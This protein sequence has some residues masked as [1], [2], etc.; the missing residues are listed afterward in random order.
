MRRSVVRPAVAIALA[1]FVVVA[2][3]PRVAFAACDPFN[4]YQQRGWAWMYGAFELNLPSSLQDRLSQ[5]GGR[6]FRGAFAMGMVGGL[7]A[8]PCTGLFL[9]GLLTFVAT[10]RSVI[11]GGWLLFVYAIGMG[12][13]FWVLA[14]FA[15]SL[16]KSG[17][18]MEWVKSAGGILLLLGGIYFLKPL[19]PF[20][21]HLAVPETWFLLTA[22]SLI[23]AGLAIGA[24]HLSFHGSALEKIRKATGIALV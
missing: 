16:P 5:V 23:I 24:I 17:R 3:V 13:L 8:A 7:M 18:W 4:E 21:R 12:V 10:S 9:L 11:G 2:V 19:L 14:A 15:M 20:M 6:G 22:I 1:V